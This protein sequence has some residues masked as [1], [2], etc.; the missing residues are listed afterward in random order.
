MAARRL[1]LQVVV[2]RRLLD[3]ARLELGHDRRHLGFGEH[4]VAHG[5]RL[6]ARVAH[7]LEGDPRTERE[8]GF[9]KHAVHSDVEIA[10]RKAVLLHLA[11]LRLARS[12][13]RPIDSRPV[14]AAGPTLCVDHAGTG[15]HGEHRC[16]QRDAPPP[17]TR[18]SMPDGFGDER[19]SHIVSHRP[20]TPGV[21]L[22]R[23]SGRT[24]W[25]HARIVGNLGPCLLTPLDGGA[26]P[27]GVCPRSLSSAH[28]PL[29]HGQGEEQDANS[30]KCAGHEERD[31]G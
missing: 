11:R 21:T 13:D 8:R 2:E 14:S 17:A 29:I 23:W 28:M 1:V 24:N 19:E 9:H 5:H 27:V 12:A 4:E 3:T 20:G 22:I 25:P 10:S 30:A 18:I 15:G 16:S 6:T 7:A 31:G 26:P